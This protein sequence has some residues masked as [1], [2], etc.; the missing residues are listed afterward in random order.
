MRCCHAMLK[1]PGEDDYK[2]Q[3]VKVSKRPLDKLHQI[4]ENPSSLIP[5]HMNLNAIRIATPHHS[6]V[7]LTVWKHS[8]SHAQC[9]LCCATQWSWPLCQVLEDHEF[10]AGAC[11]CNANLPDPEN[12]LTFTQGV[13]LNWAA[14]P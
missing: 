7:W 6:Y 11:F 1:L 2:A 10:G 8:E 4:M 14:A 5:L 13:S 9:E 3:A 12:C